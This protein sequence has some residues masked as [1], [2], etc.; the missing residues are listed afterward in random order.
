MSHVVEMC[1]RILE[2]KDF[3]QSHCH[4]LLFFLFLCL[5]VLKN[6]HLLSFHSLTSLT[7]PPS[8]SPSPRPPVDPSGSVQRSQPNKLAK[9]LRVIAGRLGKKGTRA[10]IKNKHTRVERKHMFMCNMFMCALLR[11]SQF[12]C[13]LHIFLSC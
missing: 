9:S 5:I 11:S 6:N 1:S 3:V 8:C 10:P 7:R 4:R 13:I 2:I 12:C